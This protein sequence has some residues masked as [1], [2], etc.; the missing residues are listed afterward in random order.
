MSLKDGMRRTRCT[1]CVRALCG[2][3]VL[4]L[5]DPIVNEAE[6]LCGRFEDA[7][8]GSSYEMWS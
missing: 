8:F 6:N 4:G 1:L 2:A 7:C 5:T 3:L